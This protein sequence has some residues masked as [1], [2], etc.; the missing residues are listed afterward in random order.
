MDWIQQAVGVLVNEYPERRSFQRSGPVS[1]DTLHQFFVRG[2]EMFNSAEFKRDLRLMHKRGGDPNGVINNGQ[3]LIF[4]ELGVQGDY[5]LAYLAQVRRT[6]GDDHR[7]M[8]AFYEF[9]AKEELVVDELEL[10]AEEFQR[11]LSV[12][13]HLKAKLEDAKQQLDQLSPD[14][15]KQYMLQLYNSTIS[16]N[17][18]QSQSQCSHCHHPGSTRQNEPET[19]M[20]R[21]EQMAFFQKLQSS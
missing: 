4:E 17:H 20:T 11:K 9:V 14:E 15:R 8:S 21:E 10:S 2:T 12:T 7:L 16:L 6:Y 18:G 19:A 3:R 1:K 5:G 13:A